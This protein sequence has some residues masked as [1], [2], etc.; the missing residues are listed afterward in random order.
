MDLKDLAPIISKFA[1]LLGSA[2]GGPIGGI[3]ATLISN[4]FGTTNPDEI[5]TALATHP[6][7]GI[8]LKELEL[9]HKAELLQI[10]STR[11]KQDDDDRKSARDREEDVIK[12]T[13][14]YDWVQH[15]CALILVFGF[16]VM[17]GMIAADHLDEKDHDLLYMLLGVLGTNFTQIYQYYFGSSRAK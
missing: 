4:L 5:N 9:Q 17:C 3:A 10:E 14:K 8:K 11:E 6:D 13:G 1:P 2:L 12:L 7:A 16:F 15:L